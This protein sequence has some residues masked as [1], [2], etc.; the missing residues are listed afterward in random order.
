MREKEI[1][2][3]GGGDG[4]TIGKSET[5]LHTMYSNFPLGT[6]IASRSS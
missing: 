1:D 6:G 3:G 4:G 2:R 5:T